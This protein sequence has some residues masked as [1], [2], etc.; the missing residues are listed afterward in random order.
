MNSSPLSQADAAHLLLERRLI[1][2]SFLAFCE[3]ALAPLG[4]SPQAHHRLLI[5]RLQAVADNQI[6]RLMVMMPPGSAKSTYASVLFP[7]WFM[8]RG[9]QSLITASHTATLA[10]DFGRRVINAAREHCKTL[11]YDHRSGGGDLWYTTNDCRVLSAGVGGAVTGSRA[12]LALIDDPVKSREEADS[13]RIRDV[14]HNWFRAD[15]LTRLKPGGRIVLIMTRWHED[16]LAG[17][18]LMDEPDRWHKLCLPAIADVGDPLGRAPGDAL[19]P[20]WQPLATLEDLRRSL[21][22]RDFASLYQQ[23]PRAGDGTIFNTSLIR[24][25]DAAP[26]GGKLIRAWDLAATAQIGTRD[27]DWTVGVLLQKTAENGFVIHDV[28]RLRGGPDEVEATITATASRDGRN[29]TISLPQD[30]GQAGKSQ[31]LYLTRKLMGYSVKSH[32]IT[33]DK[34]TRAAPFASQ[35]NVG[36]VAMVRA[37]WNRALLDE[38]ASFPSGTHDD[39]VDAGSDAFAELIAPP[40]PARMANF[41]VMAR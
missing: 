12:D 33:G 14:A 38:M 6:D 16:D 35:V 40:E 3:Y 24:T 4:Q 37:Q 21:G 26:A 17:R 27:P 28:A 36:N 13:E 39:Q 11:G 18:L 9:D 29:V 22:E 41:N 1:R 10:Q 20:A 23:S 2:R 8:I 25:I 31:V 19:W 7:A 15:L 34:A 32:S 30:P 5:A